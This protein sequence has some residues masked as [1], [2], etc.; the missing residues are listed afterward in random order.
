MCY[1]FVCS[2][3]AGD[4]VVKKKKNKKKSKFEYI[5]IFWPSNSS[6]V[7]D[8]SY[9]NIAVVCQLSNE[10]KWMSEYSG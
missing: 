3:G 9:T 6:L 5:I 2:Q 10:R 7:L 8:L 4:V 1:L